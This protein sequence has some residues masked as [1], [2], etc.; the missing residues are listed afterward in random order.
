VVGHGRGDQR[1]RELH[2]QRPLAAG[3]KHAFPVDLSQDALA[4]ISSL[5][6]R[7]FCD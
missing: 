6:F 5:T 2:D 3:E 1:V 7:E 4:H